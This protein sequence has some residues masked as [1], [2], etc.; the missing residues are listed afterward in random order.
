MAAFAT[1]TNTAKQ[2]R[3]AGLWRMVVKVTWYP[4]VLGINRP[5]E[6]AWQRF[7]VALGG[8]PDVFRA[9]VTYDE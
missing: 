8:K 2:S 6:W 1:E 7:W 3:Y 5:H 9:K 4:T